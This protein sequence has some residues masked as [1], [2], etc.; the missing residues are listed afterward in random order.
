MFV[1]NLTLRLQQAQLARTGDSF[2]A[3]LNLEFAKDFLIVPFHRV[4]GQEK[5]CANLPIRET[6]GNQLED[7]QL[8][9]A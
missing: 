3:P 5:L 7:F 1:G 6:M 9:L 2:G 4:Q 8:A